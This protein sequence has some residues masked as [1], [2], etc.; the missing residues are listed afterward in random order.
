MKIAFLSRYQN[1]SNRGVET[2]I[3]ELSSRLSF[4]HQVE[5]LSGAEADDLQK[6][7]NGKFDVVIP[8][9]GRIQSLKTSL[10]RVA[11]Q[12]KL[13]ISGHSGIGRDDIWNIVVARP[14]VF[15]ALTDYMVEWARKWALGIKVV[16]ISNGIDLEKFK[17]EG[18][19]LKIDLEGPIILSVGALAWYKHHERTIEAVAKLGKGSLL[20]IGKGEEEEK[21]RML[22]KN[23]LADRFKIISL[24]YEDLPKAYRAAQLFTLPSWEREAFGIVYL[25]AMA[26]G[27][28]V[29]A[30]DD[31]SRREIIGNA[32]VLVDVSD[33]TAFASG[34]RQVLE[35]T[36][37]SKPRKQAEKFSWDI[38]SKRYEN[39]LKEVVNG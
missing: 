12:Y 2:F 5:I 24:P 23:L 10:G 18:E 37:D 11:G 7:L 13:L 38:I 34:I 6:V 32:G 20:I 19:K 16:K 39:I 26:S 31:P 36:W 8:T 14:D 27:L 35:K 1:E 22:G 30:P 21:L 3:R 4:D 33:S 28:P 15:V 25:E 17:P 9:N 29:V